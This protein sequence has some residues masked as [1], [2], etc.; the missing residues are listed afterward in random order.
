MSKEC[1]NCKLIHPDEAL[2]CECGFDFSTGKGATSVRI[3]PL[4]S[5]LSWAL[6][7]SGGLA[8]GR[9]YGA[10]GGFIAG[11]LLWVLRNLIFSILY[12]TSPFRK[13]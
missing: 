5:Y 13:R 9:E 8:F 11:F 7:L 2:R 4:I 10:V 3:N 12:H 6:Y 1:P